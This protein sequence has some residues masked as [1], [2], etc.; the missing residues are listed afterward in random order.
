MTPEKQ[1]QP[2]LWKG[3]LGAIALSWLP[4]VLFLALSANQATEPKAFGAA[5]AG[6]M[7]VIVVYVTFR[8]QA[9][10]VVL[11]VPLMLFAAIAG[12]T[13]LGT[14]HSTPTSG[15]SAAPLEGVAVLMMLLLAAGLGVIVF[16]GA[17]LRPEKWSASLLVI[18][19]LNAGLMSIA[20]SNG[21]RGVTKQE[22]ILHLS[23][24]FGRPISG[25]AVKYE[26]FGYG[27]GGSEVFEASDSPLYSDEEGVVRV[28]SRRM[29]YKTQ[30]MISKNGFREITVLLGT[31][32]SES[33]KSRDYSLSTPETP[34]IA[35]GTVLA[36][37]PL[38]IPLCLSRLA[39]AP[40]SKVR[41]LGLYSKHDLPQTVRP[42]SLDLETGKFAADLSGDLELEYFSAT[43][44]RFRDQRLRIRGLNGV[45]LFLVSHNEC[46]PTVHTL[47]EQLYRIAPQ[48]GYQ[49]EVIIAN[50]GNSPGPVVYVRASDGKL[51]GRLCLEALGD[52]VN[53]TPRYSGTLEINPS[54]RN[55]EWVKKND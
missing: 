15:P 1:D 35:T 21:Y 43:K 23:D 31:Q 41:H 39:D 3:L 11:W 18:A 42:K 51:H 38:I 53:E 13:L 40:S 22:I 34:A 9:W 54:G 28:P 8:K 10:S 44:T 19:A 30:M 48:S 26:R 32:V 25:A 49:Q 33:D 2:A 6:A 47:Y 37:D 5:A 16:T 27:S 7:L 55:L 20:S 50:P 52:G 17:W 24:S 36:S 14:G 29:R 12:L 4:V 45:Q 46:L